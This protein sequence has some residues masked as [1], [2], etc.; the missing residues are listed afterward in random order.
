M[1]QKSYITLPLADLVP[2]HRNNK[3]HSDNVKRIVASIERN[4]YITPIIVDE[5]N[6]IIVWHGRR[7]ALLRMGR[8]E[9]EVLKICGLSDKQKADIRI[10]DN[11]VAEMSE[12]DFDNIIAEV[13]EFGLDDIKIDFPDLIFDDID[14]DEDHED[15][16]PD[17]D[18]TPIIVQQ[19]D[20]FRLG[21]H[22]LMCGDSMNEAD[23]QTLLAS[24]NAWPKTHC[25][26]DPPY[27][28]A[29]NPDKHGM[30]ANDDK[31]LDY[32][33]L[34][35]KY[36]DWFF[37]MRTGYQV[38]SQRI[39]LIEA[40]FDKVTN[41]IIRHKGGG[42]MGDC[43][44]TLAQD[45]EILLVN[46]RGNDLTGYREWAVW[47]YQDK[48]KQK[49]IQSAKK[50]D[51]QDLLTH[52][53]QG[54]TVWKVGKDNNLEYLHPTQKPVQINQ[55]VLENFTMPRENVLDLFG[56]SGSNLLACEKT[57][58]IC[59]M[60]ELDPTYI[61]VIIRRYYDYTKGAREIECVNRELDLT[62]LYDTN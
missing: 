12:R 22:T 30:I 38:V 10:S 43:M 11:K 18:D 26:S 51:L 25:I 52:E 36:S 44:R 27:W 20:I 15:T 5:D 33:A 49:R 9:V 61:Q 14:L 4:E 16:I 19:G 40:T 17:M 1:L 42:G 29:Y 24:K 53:L 48:E 41:M 45:F 56:G 21:N 54:N 3:I 2:Y 59:Y 8:E 13:Q 39:Q 50:P 35:K 46:H 62:P 34:A 7:L 57:D 58:R 31:I 28:I 23:I 47:K 37:C 32:T 60:M 55:R 6:V